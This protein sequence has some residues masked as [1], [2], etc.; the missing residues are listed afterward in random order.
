MK[1]RTKPRITIQ[2]RRSSVRV[3]YRTQAVY[4]ADAFLEARYHIQLTNGDNGTEY[5]YT[6]G[7]PADTK[8]QMFEDSRLHAVSKFLYRQGY[9]IDKSNYQE[10]DMERVSDVTLLSYN[11][12]YVE[13]QFQT[14]DSFKRGGKIVMVE[15]DAKGRIRG[16]KTGV[17][18]GKSVIEED[19]KT[20][21]VKN[22]KQQRKRK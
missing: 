7:V 15:R 3:G 18:P 8:K 11:F 2:E 9:F 14:F 22:I 6:S 16:S 13:N 5:G 17:K 19:I 4:P 12:Y 21:I 20:D 1:H 10:L